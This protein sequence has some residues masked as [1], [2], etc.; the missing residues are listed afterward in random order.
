VSGKPGE[1]QADL[2]RGLV[3]ALALM[4]LLFERAGVLERGQRAVLGER[5]RVSA[6]E[7]AGVQRDRDDLAVADA[8]FDAATDQARVQRVVAGIEAQ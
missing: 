7:L 8:G 3:A 4:A 6:G 1:L 5:A 2:D